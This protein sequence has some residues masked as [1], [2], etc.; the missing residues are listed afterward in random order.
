[1]FYLI[2]LVFAVRRWFAFRH[3]NVE[4]LWIKFIRIY[5]IRHGITAINGLSHNVDKI[6]KARH[7]KNFFKCGRVTIVRDLIHAAL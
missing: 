2:S 4:L 1:M 6:F 5:Y 7:C 3:D